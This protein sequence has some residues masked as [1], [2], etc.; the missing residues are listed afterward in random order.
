M[1][2]A[3]LLPSKVATFLVG[4][5]AGA[6]FTILIFGW[7]RDGYAPSWH[8]PAGFFVLAVVGAALQYRLHKS[9]GDSGA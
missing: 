4:A 5:G 8:I 6:C 9:L 3:S 2:K 7:I 1:T